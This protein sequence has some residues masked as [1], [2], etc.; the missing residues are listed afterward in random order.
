M[1]NISPLAGTPATPEMRVDV[2]ALV[3]AYFDRKPDPSV[4]EQQVAFGTSGHRG[5]SF[6]KSFYE[7]HVLAITQA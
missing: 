6:E 1:T 2:G 7:A 3:A 5:S 4:A